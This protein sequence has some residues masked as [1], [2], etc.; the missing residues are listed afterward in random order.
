MVCAILAI[1]GQGLAGVAQL[2]EHNVAN[3]VVVGSNPITRSQSKLGIMKTA[4]WIRGAYCF[5]VMT[6]HGGGVQTRNTPSRFEFLVQFSSHKVIRMT[7]EIE[8][9]ETEKEE[10]R[11][12]LQMEVQVD[13]PSA[14][15]RHITVTISKEDV[16]RYFD[17][18]FSELMPKAEV[19]GFRSGRAPRKLVESK[20]KSEVSDQVKGSLLMDSMTQITEEHDFSAISEPDFDFEAVELPDD[21][22]LTFEFD[23]EVRPEFDMP[24]WKGL[25]L[26]RP[27]KEFSKKDV[28]RHIEE[29]LSRRGTLTPFEGAAE[30]GDYVVCN[31]VCTVDGKLVSEAE[32]QTIR[33]LPVLSFPDGRIDD[34]DKLMI[35]AQAGDKKETKI[36]ISHDAPNED[37]Q[38]K[39]AKVEFEVLEVKKLELPKL[40]DELLDRM[41]NF[42]NE[43]DFRDAIKKELERRLEYQ[44]QRRIREQILQQLTEAADWDLPPELLKRQSRRELDRAV[45]ELRSAGYNEDE[46]QAYENELRQN[47]MSSTRKALHE[48]FILERIAEEQEIEA[49]DD[50]YEMEIMMIAAQSGEPPRRVRARIE[51]RGMMDALRNQI[52][53]RKVIN[54]ITEEASFKDVEYEPEK[55]RTEAVEHFIC[56]QNDGAIPE[57]KH[58]GESQ[59]LKL[60][61][62]RD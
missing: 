34:F 47:S 27:M 22:A 40:D 24:K 60:P 11:Q 9:P 41:G 38:G 54:L 15:Q 26:E 25:T 6:H 59:E 56:G 19:P 7:T 1:F 49:A 29:S 18:A 14:C 39:E 30:E 32:E 48:H 3:V 17:E 10:E 28:D 31:L 35:G 45:L 37:F 12:P 46:I 33:V 58:A 55:H 20:F 8:K 5:A 13:K 50:D 51:K 62:D 44:Q 57:A 42:E 23:L 53:E 36:L 4:P 21:G 16:Q 2:A 52:I 43:G 61:T